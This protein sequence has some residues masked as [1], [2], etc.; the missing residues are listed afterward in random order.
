QQTERADAKNAMPAN[1]VTVALTPEDAEL[2]ALAQEMGSLRLIL[3]GHGDNKLSRTR[4]GNGLMLTKGQ[5]R[6]RE[7]ASV[8][9]EEAATSPKVN[10]LIRRV[11]EVK[12]K[13][14]ADQQ[15]AE[16]KPVVEVKGLPP[17]TTKTHVLTI[18]NGDQGRRYPFKLDQNDQVVREEITETDPEPS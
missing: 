7:K 16:E 6:I 4:G 10:A 15:P 3:R 11:A 5:H 14:S 9:Q 17:A 1:T 12:E 2:V 13:K 18:Y 8:P